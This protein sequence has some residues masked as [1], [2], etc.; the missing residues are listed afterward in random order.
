MRRLAIGLLITA[1]GLG[2]FTGSAGA[3]AGEGDG[4]ADAVAT[5]DLGRVDVLLVS[6]LF[7]RLVVEAIEGAIDDAVAADAQAL[8]IQ[9]NSRGAVVGDERMEELQG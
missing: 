8:I 3:G 6:G 9:V 7:D 1:V 4:G 2:L 5:P